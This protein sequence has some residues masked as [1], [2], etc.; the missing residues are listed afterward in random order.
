MM[1][2]M[3]KSSTCDEPWKPTVS[4]IKYMLMVVENPT[5]QQP[6]IRVHML[7]HT[8]QDFVPRIT[9][10]SQHQPRVARSLTVND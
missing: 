6:P 9:H 2:K 3:L 7:S 10:R 8:G 5:T 4:D 1:L